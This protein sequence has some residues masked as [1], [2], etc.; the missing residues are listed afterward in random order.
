M[1]EDLESEIYLTM[2][3]VSGLVEVEDGSG[4]TWSADL[5]LRVPT[6]FN[7]DHDM[8][9]EFASKVSCPHLVIKATGSPKYMSDEDYD[10]MLKV[11]KY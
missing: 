11:W 6:A 10:K 8:T 5:R 1:S 4:Y 2:L 9:E 3:Q 7:M